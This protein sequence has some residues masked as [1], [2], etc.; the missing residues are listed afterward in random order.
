MMLTPRRI[1]QLLR[2]V[3]RRKLSVAEAY[4]QL[5]SLPYDEL[6]FATLDTHRAI[7]R[8]LP[9]VVFCDGKTVEQVR[10]I[11]ERLAP[12]TDPLICGDCMAVICRRCGAPLEDSDEL[13]MG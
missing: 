6:G 7:R 8:G 5:R 12:V 11:V 3:S 10:R 2:D 4:E 9:E 1:Q 13:G